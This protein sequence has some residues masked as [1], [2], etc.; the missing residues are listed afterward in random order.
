VHAILERLGKPEKLIR[1]VADRPGH[2]R[3]YAVDTTRIRQELG[4][5]PRRDW[6]QTLDDTV[7]WYV[8]NPEW[9]HAI[10]NSDPRFQ[11]YYDRQYGERL[12]STA[13]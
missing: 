6:R 4:W 9:W 13:G 12:A 7:D 11:D 2:D 10:R 5:E 8:A 1:H 3:R